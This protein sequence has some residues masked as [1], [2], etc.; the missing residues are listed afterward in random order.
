MIQYLS[1]SSADY[2][3]FPDLRTTFIVTEEAL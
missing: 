2:E 1:Q 3:Q